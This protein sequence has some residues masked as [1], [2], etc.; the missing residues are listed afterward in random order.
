MLEGLSARGGACLGGVWA[1]S[2]WGQLEP[3]LSVVELLGWGGV[4]A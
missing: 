4:D 3:R 2:R 1:G